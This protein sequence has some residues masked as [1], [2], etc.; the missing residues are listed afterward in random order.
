MH[1]L[2]PAS[3]HEWPEGPWQASRKAGRQEL[4]CVTTAEEGPKALGAGVPHQQD[5]YTIHHWSET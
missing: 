3:D 1:H 2:Y 4:D 5:S